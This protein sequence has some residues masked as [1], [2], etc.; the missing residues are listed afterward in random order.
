[1][2]FEDPKLP[3]AML[4]GEKLYIEGE[5]EPYFRDPEHTIR[6]RVDALTIL[7]GYEPEDD[8]KRAGSKVLREFLQGIVKLEG[9]DR[10]AVAGLETDPEAPIPE[11]PIEFQLRPVSDAETDFQW[12]A[13]IGF[14]PHDWEFNWKESFWIT[15]YCTRQYF[16]DVLAAVR[17][18]HVKN[19]RASMETTMWTK[20]K[21]SM[22][23]V[24]RTWHVA[25]SPDRESRWLA[26]EQG[27]ISSLTWE[28][29]FG[30]VEL[31]NEEQDASP[32]PNPRL[33][34]LPARLYS[35]LVTL[36][37]IAAALLVLTF[38][39]H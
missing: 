2:A 37:V 25:P 6:L 22:V 31:T 27:N 29:Q 3:R 16:D 26:L 11:T 24:L 39:R 21:S 4:R 7:R 5:S 18:G 17:R 23:E 13:N 1:M 9:R 12:R 20:D 14:R 34:E 33:L 8:F 30:P 32:A 19:I 10:F 35:M 15:G 36:I 38:L 28:E